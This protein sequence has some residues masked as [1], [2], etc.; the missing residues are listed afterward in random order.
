[1]DNNKVIS[2][3]LESNLTQNLFF[4]SK[5]RQKLNCQAM[6]KGVAYDVTP[7]QPLD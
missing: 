3:D 7:S 2:N 4:R 6:W 5:N 1:M